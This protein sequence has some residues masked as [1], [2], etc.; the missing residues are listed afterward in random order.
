MLTVLRELLTEPFRRMRK[1]GTPMHDMVFN[2]TLNWC[3]ELFA[4]V[5]LM[6]LTSRLLSVWL[7]AATSLAM[8]PFLG[9]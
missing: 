2:S 7:L 5:G 1:E 8:L 9:L 3:I 6:S 4:L